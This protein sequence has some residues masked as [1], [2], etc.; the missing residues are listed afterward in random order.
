[1]N[2]KFNTKIEQIAISDIR[3]FDTEVSAIPGI[4]KLTLGEPDFNTPDHIKQAA[5]KAIEANK[6]HY[7]PNAGLPALRKAAA[8]YYNKKFNLHYQ[9]E[10]VVTT[11][12]ATEG[13]AASLQ[14]I[15]NPDD[16][17]IVPTP[18]FPIYIPDTKIN[19]GNVI[20]VDTSKDNFVLTAD[21][22]RQVI[23]EHPLARIKA[24]VLNYPC[25]PTGVTYSRQQLEAI[26]QV[27]RDYDFWIISDEIYAELT[28]Q[29][30]H[31][32]MGEVLPEK[33]ILLTGLSKSHAM[34]GWRIGYILGPQDFIEQVVKSHQYMVTS[35]TTVSQYAALEAMTN[36]QRDSLA[37]KKEYDKR[38]AFLVKELVEAGFKTASADGA[39]YLF[40]KIPAG[41]VQDSWTFV[42]SLAQQAKVALIPGV[43][44]GPG[45]EG[46]V[47]ISYA[48]SMKQ[49]QRAATAIKQYVAQHSALS[50]GQK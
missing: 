1:M 36:G 31:I 43:S 30:K 15:I 7:T 10:Q 13:I 33:T 3:Q 39:F 16:T 8:D 9:P 25:N 32:S 19:E 4:I 44:F 6:S 48:A 26:A 45:G 47:R 21:R 37:M 20:L 2:D 42:R 50:K 17:V 41:C 46:Y 29:K 11:I 18:I 35:P 22:L 49:L 24:L 28:Y 12:G 27:A 5:I 38:R 23:E 34:T 40:A 14:T